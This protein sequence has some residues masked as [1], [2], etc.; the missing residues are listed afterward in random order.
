MVREDKEKSNRSTLKRK[1]NQVDK[2]AKRR[3][4]DIVRTHRLQRLLKLWKAVFK[5]GKE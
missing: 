3:K 4:L 2:E 5:K 1:K